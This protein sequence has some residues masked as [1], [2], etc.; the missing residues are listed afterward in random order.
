MNEADSENIAAAFRRR[1]Y[2]LTDEIK[3]AD[4]VVVNTCTVRQRAEDKAIS[5]IGRLRVWKEKRPEGKLF[6]VGC[7]AQKLG[8]KAIKNRFPFVDEVVG[9]KAIEAFEDSLINQLG[10]SPEGETAHQ[11]LFRSPQTAYVT[12]MRGCSLKCSYCIVPAVRGPAV[13]LSADAILKDAAAKIEAGAKEIVL[14]GQT[15][16]AW[17][18]DKTTFSGLL[19]KALA[20]PGLQRLRFMSPHPVYFEDDFTALLA[21]EKKLARYMHLPVQSGSDR[22]LKL[23]RRGYTRAQYLALLARLRAGTPDLAVS[24]D[25]I[26]G[27]PGETEEDFQ[28]TL[29]LVQEGRFTM[30]YCFK[31][32][33]RSDKPEMA[34][35][36]SEAEME[37]R[38]EKLLAAVKTNSRVILNERIG[39]IEEV[40]FETETYGRASGNFAVRVKAGGTP[41]KMAEVL[42]EKADKNTLNGKLL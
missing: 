8:G 13:F 4:A 20:L 36:I 31:Y 38:L 21:R 16:N 25:F 18:Q 34:A 28:D 1:G 17:R 10:P 11:N 33:P 42:V 29:K 40:L 7:A 30:A 32:S 23:M 41:G 37:A 22:I 6:V 12:I 3:K 26:V 39:K 35:T 5:Q 24:T 2:E 9:A 19:E 27:Y 15:V 14:L